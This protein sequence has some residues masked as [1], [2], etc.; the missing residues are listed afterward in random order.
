M[1]IDDR[2]D[3]HLGI[4]GIAD[5]DALVGAD[6][7][8]FRHRQHAFDRASFGARQVFGTHEGSPPRLKF[9][10]P[11]LESGRIVVAVEGD[12]V[13]LVELHGLGRRLPVLATAATISAASMAGLPP[14]IG[15]VAKESSLAAAVESARATYLAA[16]RMKEAWSLA[17]L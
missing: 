2:T 15:F 14:F 3:A 1:L 5:A 6:E 13:R 8:P 12:H 7:P 4:H 11:A 9:V 10:D 16:A 17:G